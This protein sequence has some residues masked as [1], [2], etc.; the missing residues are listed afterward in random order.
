M[1]NIHF[2]IIILTFVMAT[3]LSLA[4]CNNGGNTDTAPDD[5]TAIG[6]ETNN[7]TP[8]GEDNVH[9]DLV[10]IEDGKAKFKVVVAGGTD[11]A[12]RKRVESFISDLKKLGVDVDSYVSGSDAGSITDCEIIV[13]TDVSHRDAKYVLNPRDYGEDGYVIKVV[14]DKVLIGGGNAAQT[15]NAFEYFIKN[16]VKLTSKTKEMNE[17][18]IDRSYERLKE[19]TY[20]IDSVEIAGTDLSEFVFITNV[21]DSNELA[22]FQSLLY[23]NTG[24]WLEKATEDSIPEGKKKFSVKLV[25]DAGDDGFRA[26]VD[27]D[28]NFIVECAYS[29]AIMPAFEHLA[30]EII[31]SGIGNVSISKSFEKTYPVNVVY[32][33]QFGAVGDGNA[34]DYQAIYNAHVFANE[35]GQKVMG[36]GPDAKYYIHAIAESIPVNTDVDFC[37]ATFLVNDRGSEVYLHRG[38]IFKFAPSLPVKT[39][40]SEQIASKFGEV[41]LHFG[42]T[43]I[44]W[45]VGEI[46]VTSFVYIKSNFKDYIRHGSNISSGQNKHDVFV[47][48]PNGKLHEDTPVIY[49]FV[50]GEQLLNN[51]LKF[52]VISSPAIVEINIYRADEKPL[53]MENG[54]FERNTCEVVAETG[55]E[56]KYAAYERGISI[57]RCNVTIKNLHNKIVSEAYLPTTGYGY[58][59]DMKLR[60]AYPYHGFVRFSMCYNGKVIDCDLNAHT[61]YF[62]AKSTSANP[63]AMGSYDIVLNDT[64]NIYFEGI[65]NGVPIGDT[66]YW[67]IMGSGNTKNTTFKSCSLNRFDAHEGLWNASLID[68]EYGHSINV[69]GGGKFYCE[70]T[71]KEVGNTFIYLR[72]DYGSTFR[73]TVELV[74]CTL[75]GFRSYRGIDDPN[76]GT[77]YSDSEKM[78]IIQ[79]N[80]MDTYKGAFD[81]SQASTYP[82]LKWDFGY[83]CYMPQDVIIDNFTFEH[84]T[85][86]VFWNISDACFVKPSDFVQP[87]DYEGKTINGRPMTPADVYYNQYQMTKSIVFKNMNPLPVCSD[88]ISYLFTELS[89]RVT[90]E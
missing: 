71:T 36:D 75:K 17:L 49:D 35:S 48:E 33:S 3:V 29:N 68:C 47:I 11:A 27:S 24:Y 5:D 88:E 70:N 6:G 44:P 9:K 37:G 80:Y 43:E 30:D 1:K 25:D 73:G 57:Q 46:E 74:N 52:E 10:L 39:Y 20:L 32:Y 54:Y 72:G 58:D 89:K 53:T 62:E 31:F 2:K 15:K 64:S 14:D 16:V 23:K 42:D 69:I 12:I 60:Q 50:A 66:Q 51:G 84:G 21:I 82:Y 26:Y 78:T 77:Y 63:V 8:P 83:T 38:A 67:G 13:G 28:S 86:Y 61:T 18:T 85:P 59:D 19:T 34:E 4:S 22:K 45:L 90:V 87:T 76:R 65:T 79:G 56:N 41:E 7:D 81:P 40:N 55:F